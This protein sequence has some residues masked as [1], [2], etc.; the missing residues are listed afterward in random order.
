[1]SDTTQTA[2]APA[3]PATPDDVARSV[4]VDDLSVSFGGI[5]AVR[6]VTVDLEAGSTCCILGPNG[7]GK[8]TVANAI[9][10][11][12]PS[13]KGTVW[14]GGQDVSGEVLYQRARHGLAYIP[15]DGAIFPTLTVAEN[16]FV[17]MGRLG[18]AERRQ[19]VD[20]AVEMYPFLGK[21]QNE[22]AGMLSGGE[23]QMLA[24][25]RLLSRTPSVTIID[26]ISHGLAPIIVDRLFASLEAAKGSTTLII[27]EQHIQKALPLADHVLVLAQGDVTYWGPAANRTAAEIESYYR[28]SA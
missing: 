21:R 3:T 13:P 12:L 8:T 20:A 17:G 9:A 1:M 2:A 28:L 4:R 24:L 14:I 5:S 15:A 18:S 27:I 22:K 16:L 26:E 19:I 10:G 6:N 25:A 7:A 11:A 23:Q